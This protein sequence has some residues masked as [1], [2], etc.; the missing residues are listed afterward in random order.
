MPD[1]LANTLAAAHK[2]KGF[3][4]VH[5]SQRCPH[6]DPDAFDYK[7]SNWFSFLNHANG[8][9]PDKRIADKTEVVEHDPTSLEGAFKYASRSRRYFGLFYHNPNKPCYDEILLK[10]R[11]QAEKKP[12]SKILDRF[13]I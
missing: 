2:H 13:Q 7:T 4:F 5:I 3:S 9:G 12:R 6:Y 11:E 10:Q 8:I 1:H